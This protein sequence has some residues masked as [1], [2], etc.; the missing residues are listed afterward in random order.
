M[1]S[2]LLNNDT[3]IVNTNLTARCGATCA[4]EA[5]G[6]ERVYRPLRNCTDTVLV[7]INSLLKGIKKVLGTWEKSM[8]ENQGAFLHWTGLT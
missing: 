1:N 2:N 3:L 8:E 4:E 6:G 7:W 5:Q